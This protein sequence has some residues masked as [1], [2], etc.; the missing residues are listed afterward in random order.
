MGLVRV[1]SVSASPAAIREVHAV[2][3]G[4]SSSKVIKSRSQGLD[5]DS[6]NVMEADATGESRFLNTVFA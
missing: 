5:R 3:A 6:C 1:T 2:K 4:P